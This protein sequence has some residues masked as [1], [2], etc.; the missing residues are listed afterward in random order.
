MTQM[1]LN[2]KDERVIPTLTK[3]VRAFEGV[4]IQHNKLSAYER[5][6][7]EARTGQVARF[8]SLD[9]FFADLEG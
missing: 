7:Q 9:A 4:S 3:V 6:K 2:I 1:V 5:S 8:D